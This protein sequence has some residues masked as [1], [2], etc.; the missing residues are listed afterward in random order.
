MSRLWILADSGGGAPNNE[1][2]ESTVKS[3][4]RRYGSD[5]GST[6]RQRKIG[7]PNNSSNN[8]NTN[9][10]VPMKLVWESKRLRAAASSIALELFTRR[11]LLQCC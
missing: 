10:K 2:T 3:L 7:S 8:I 5:R 11:S 6:N 1:S 9:N 4:R